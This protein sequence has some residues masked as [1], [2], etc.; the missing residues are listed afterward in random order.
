MMS[1]GNNGL[2]W[3]VHIVKLGNGRITEV[4]LIVAKRSAMRIPTNER[5]AEMGAAGAHIH[6]TLK[7]RREK[8]RQ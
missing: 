4:R 8:V 5:S 3:L 7:T 2:F 1:C 6:P